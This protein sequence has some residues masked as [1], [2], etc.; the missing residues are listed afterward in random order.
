MKYIIIAFALLVSACAGTK[1]I[2]TVE[3]NYR[4]DSTGKY[5]R[6]DNSVTTTTEEITVPVTMPADTLAGRFPLIPHREQ[7]IETPDQRIT[8]RYDSAANAVDVKAVKKAKTVQT[9]AKKTTVKKNDIKE[10]GEATKTE[11]ATHEED[12]TKKTN[13]NFMPVLLVAGAVFLLLALI[14]IFF[15]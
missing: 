6:V 15:R 10:T 7:V 8:F 9:P 14:K 3:D 2:H 12:K 11:A 13:I 4:A 1:N 5:E